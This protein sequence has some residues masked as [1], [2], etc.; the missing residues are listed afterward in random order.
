MIKTQFCAHLLIA[1]CL[2]PSIDNMHFKWIVLVAMVL[3]VALTFEPVDAQGAPSFP[4]RG[5]GARL[6]RVER[7]R[8]QGG[9]RRGGKRVGGKPAGAKPAGDAPAGGAQD[10]GA[11]TGGAPTDS[12]GAGGE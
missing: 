8:R 9:R 5:M 10:G 2:I 7:S 12:A 6:A 1:S 11:P 4:R 3:M